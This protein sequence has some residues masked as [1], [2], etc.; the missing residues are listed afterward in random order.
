M[1]RLKVEVDRYSNNCL[2]RITWY[3]RG[4]KHMDDGDPAETLFTE[5]GK[6]AIQRW[7]EYGK[8]HRVDGPAYIDYYESGE[9]KHEIWF[10]NGKYHRADGSAM[11]WYYRSG[12]VRSEV[13]YVNGELI[14]EEDFKNQLPP[15][16]EEEELSIPELK[17]ELDAALQMSNTDAMVYSLVTAL[18][19]FIVGILYIVMV[20]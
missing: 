12:E 9:V 5:D 18:F 14:S 8:L 6:V 7:Y 11:I 1:S 13:W 2:K 15:I 10:A 20:M 4:K 19:I 16:P 3:L 17:K